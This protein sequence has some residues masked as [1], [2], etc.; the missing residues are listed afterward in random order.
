ELSD[1]NVNIKEIVGTDL[2]KQNFPLIYT[3][4]A[5][6]K[7][8]PRLVEIIAEKESAPTLTLVGKGVTFDSGGLDIKPSNGMRYMQKD[9]GGA[10]HM[11]AL[12]KWI[13]E[14]EWN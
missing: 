11:L 9:M 4:G 13:L 14:E 7:Y 8:H 5:A 12:A 10:A 1:L 6:S 2:L 3:V